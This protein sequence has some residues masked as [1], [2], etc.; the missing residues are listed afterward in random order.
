M[1]SPVEPASPAEDSSVVLAPPPRRHA[2]GL[3]AGSVRAILALGVLGLL[4]AITL[5]YDS[6]D[7]PLAERKLP[8]AFIYLQFLMILIFAHF[9][10]AHGSTI[11]PRVSR[12]SPLGLPRGSIRFVLLAGYLGLA[13]YLYQTQPEFSFPA[14]G[15]FILLVGLLLGG[16][17]LGHV[18]SGVMRVVGRGQLPDWFQDFEA[19][20]AL[21]ALFALG[22]LL[23]VYLFINPSVSEKYKLDMPTLQAW[24]AAAVGFYFGARS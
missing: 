4:W 16:F 24:L 8:L 23:I 12:R 14:S 1:S 5:R 22:I 11:G 20:V 3:P 9:F 13:V 10:A 18:S 15:P 19:W 2:L 17:V 6:S 21:L 7:V